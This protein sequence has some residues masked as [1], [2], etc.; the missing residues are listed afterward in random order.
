MT[1]YGGKEA[2]GISGYA[3]AITQSNRHGLFFCEPTRS[4]H[5]VARS[6]HTARAAKFPSGCKPHK[7][8]LTSAKLGHSNYKL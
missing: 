7:P 4:A 5:R 8:G 6:A 2:F 3:D 1:P